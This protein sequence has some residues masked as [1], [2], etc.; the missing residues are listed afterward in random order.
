MLSTSLRGAQCLCVLILDHALLRFCT[1]YRK[2]HGKDS[3]C[4]VL[5]CPREHFACKYDLHDVNTLGANQHP[6]DKRR[7]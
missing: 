2:L 4:C 1:I 7:T 6:F 5:V 3:I